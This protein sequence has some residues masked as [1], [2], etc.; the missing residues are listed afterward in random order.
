M[1]LDESDNKEK[2]EK[3]KK[4]KF[5]VNI[6]LS[7]LLLNGCTSTHIEK[8]YIKEIGQ[9]DG[10]YIEEEDI[11]V[12]EEE[13][14]EE[15]KA[16]LME[17]AQSVEVTT[18]GIQN[19]D[20]AFIH[21]KSENT[22]Q[23]YEEET[24]CE[25]IVGDGD[26]DKKFEQ[27]LIGMKSGDEKEFTI[28]FDETCNNENWRNCNVNFNVKIYKIE[29]TAFPKLTKEFLKEKYGFETESEFREYIQ[30]KIYQIKLSEYEEE[31]KEQAMKSIISNTIFNDIY[32]EKCKERYKKVMESYQSY[33]DLNNVTIEEVLKIFNQTEDELYKK[34]EYN[35]ACYEICLYIVDKENLQP[36]QVEFISLEQK[37]VEEYGY[38][39]IEEFIADNG[40]ESLEESIYQNIGLDYIYSHA[41]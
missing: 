41:N 16:C 8:Y 40:K 26:F 33:A 31:A 22:S 2:I 34:A 25:I 29:E 4:Y 35:E 20:I 3:M 17:Y 19:E 9:Y 14:I 32:D 37:Y 15:L 38:D 11:E 1:N 21:Y 39:T 10:V 30:D 36:S 28:K 7:I 23:S 24:D 6:L 13:I 5:I 27:E 18:R 12:S